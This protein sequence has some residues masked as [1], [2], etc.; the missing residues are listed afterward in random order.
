MHSCILSAFTIFDMNL[1]RTIVINVVVL[2]EFTGSI[3]T[4]TLKR[5]KRCGMLSNLKFRICFG[6]EYGIR[7]WNFLNLSGNILNMELSFLKQR[8]FQNLHFG[9]NE[10]PCFS[11]FR[12]S[13]FNKETF[14]LLNI[15][16]WQ[17]CHKNKP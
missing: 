10:I 2:K 8:Y 6:F 7:K 12:K 14:T 9:E 11:I 16:N 3:E 4:Q 15:E 13:S 5:I 17:Y 1:R